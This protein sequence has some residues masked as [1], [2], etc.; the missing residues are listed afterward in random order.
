[1]PGGTDYPQVTGRNI[2]RTA[3]YM[4]NGGG[5]AVPGLALVYVGHIPDNTTTTFI[6]MAD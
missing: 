6:D 5:G 1:M 2:F 4:P 3:Y